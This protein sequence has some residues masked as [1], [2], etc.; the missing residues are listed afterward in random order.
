MPPH[1]H[2]NALTEEE[3]EKFMN[4]MQELAHKDRRILKETGILLGNTNRPLFY[5]TPPAWVVI[6]HMIIDLISLVMIVY[7]WLTH[8]TIPFPFRQSVMEYV[9]DNKLDN[10]QCS[11]KLKTLMGMFVGYRVNG[12][13][14]K[15]FASSVDIFMK[16]APN[17][18][19]SSS[20][21]SLKSDTKHQDIDVP[22]ILHDNK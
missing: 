19:N 4:F 12:T 15:E 3:E 18:K 5:G 14:E 20:T 16:H 6:P 13:C 8:K 10:R 11:T 21:I 22:K 17:D 2:E 1:T 9:K 7:D